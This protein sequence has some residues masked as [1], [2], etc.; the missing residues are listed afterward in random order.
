MSAKKLAVC[1]GINYPGTSSE[2]RGC[3]NDA[4]SWHRLLTD[5]GYVVTTILD[6]D[7]TRDNVLHILTQHLARLRW[8]D[9]LVFTFSGHGTWLPDLDGDEQDARDEALCMVDFENFGLIKDDEL[10]SLLS[11]RAFGSRVITLSDSCFSG[12]V[13]RQ[14]MADVPDRNV[15]FVDP[16]DVLVHE[17]FTDRIIQRK[18]AFANAIIENGEPRNPK[19]P[20]TKST[21]L[22]GCHEEEVAYDAYIRGMWQGAFTAA[23]VETHVTGQS[24]WEWHHK[25]REVLPSRS[26]PQHPQLEATLWQKGWKL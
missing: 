17:G 15:K 5:E 19:R 7:A 6:A 25:I 8:R 11:I 16:R 1:V 10:R 21:L 24:L 9:S 18:L 20:A 12:S 3:V 4:F 14:I 13:T 2:L 22:S 23:A 26:Y